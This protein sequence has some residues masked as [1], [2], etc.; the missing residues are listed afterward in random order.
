M[1]EGFYLKCIDGVRDPAL[2]PCEGEEGRER[3]GPRF[4]L[5]MG[6]LFANRKQVVVPL[7]G[8]QVS[9]TWRLI[10]LGFTTPVSFAAV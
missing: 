8:K 6:S 7:W 9:A 4:N 1:V 5:K 2:G 10:S 3:Q